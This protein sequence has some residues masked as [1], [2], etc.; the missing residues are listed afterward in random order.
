MAAAIES[1]VEPI[2]RLADSAFVPEWHTG[3]RP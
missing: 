2:R 1:L 3:M